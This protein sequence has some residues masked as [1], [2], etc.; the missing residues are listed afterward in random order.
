MP[1]VNVGVRKVYYE[2][3]GEIGGTPLLLVMGTGGSCRGWLPLQVPDFSQHHRTLIFDHRG[4]GG[5]DDS[6]GPLS[7][8][9]MA[10]DTVGLLDALEIERAHV[11][12]VFMGAMVAQEMAL[13]HADRVERLVLAGT[14]S[15]PDAKRRMLLEQWRALALEGVSIDILV[16]ERLLWTLQDETLE[17]TDL[18]DQMLTFFT[19]D[20]APVSSETFAKQ[21]Q[22]CI[23]HDTADRLHEIQHPTL[24]LCGRRD[25]FT[26]PALHRELADEIPNAHLVTIQY[27]GHLVMAESAEQFNKVVLQFLN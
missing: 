7:I 22:A 1:H 10:D 8:A 11:L 24:V 13:R 12:G 14:F 5:S 18:I 3:H 9:S 4:V 17:Q 23:E 21:C 25:R 16:R 19:R 2:L 20:G 6:D 15:R 27:G 26:P